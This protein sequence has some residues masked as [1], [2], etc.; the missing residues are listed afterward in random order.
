M[1]RRIFKQCCIGC[2]DDWLRMRGGVMG[3]CELE[4]IGEEESAACFRVLSLQSPGGTEENH[5]TSVRIMCAHKESSREPHQVL[6][7]KP[8][9]LMIRC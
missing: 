9:C 2:R 7:F 4:R 8:A 6:P 1:D 5:K 3:F